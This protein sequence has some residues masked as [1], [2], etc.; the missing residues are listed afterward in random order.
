MRNGHVKS[1]E[2]DTQYLLYI[3]LHVGGLWVKALMKSPRA[4]VCC[5]AVRW[6]NNI[7]NN[8]TFSLNGG[9]NEMCSTNHHVG[10][11]KV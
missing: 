8:F 3:D 10:I 4:T 11:N 7:S 2:S 5:R 6:V 1:K 9:M